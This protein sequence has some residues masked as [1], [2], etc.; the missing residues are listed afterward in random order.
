MRVFYLPL[1]PYP[2]RYTL[3]LR[4]WTMAR[5]AQH[6]IDIREVEAPRLAGTERIDTGVALDA[7]GR[8]YYALRQMATLVRLLREVRPEVGP[9]DVIYAQDT[10]HPGW[11]ALPYIFEQ[12]PVDRRPRVYN[13]LLAQSIDVNDFTFPM[14]RW[15]RHF[16]LLQDRT[17]TAHLVAADC[18]VEMMRVALFE[19]PIY[20]VGLLFDRDEVRER[21]GPLK[22]WDQRHRRVVFTSRWDMEKQ[23]HF[24][25]DLITRCRHDDRFTGVEFALCTSSATLRSNLSGAVEAART[26]EQQ[27][28][29][30]I[31]EGLSKA[32][33]YRILGDS[34]VQFN[35]AKQDFISNT[36]NEA[37]AL[38]TP[39]LL[40]SHLS[41]PEAVNN[42]PR[43]LYAAWSVDDA[44][45][46]LAAM[47][48]DPPLDVVGYAANHQHGTLDRVIDLLV[49]DV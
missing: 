10:F 17:I 11:A 8:S 20:N 13:H 15:M 46:R 14:R 38:G 6:D 27:G 47:L 5:F 39:S 43:Q 31:H 25:L 19:A 44:K 49:N 16:E 23:P 45:E 22:P 7:Y 4:D 9:R 35:C 1:E 48:R 42:E 40:P 28:W 18:M 24:F 2:E 3:Q 37:S 29:L 26:F 33:Y 30:T 41:F 32:D 36:L 34:Q 12:L 21:A